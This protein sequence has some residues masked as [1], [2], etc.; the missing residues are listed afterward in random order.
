MTARATAPA[1]S[2]TSARRTTLPLPSAPTTTGAQ[3]ARRSVS[4]R[5]PAASRARCTTRSP[6]RRPGE[7]GVELA[8][9]DDAAEVRAADRDG[10]ARDG[11]ARGIDPRVGN[12]KRDAQL[13]EQAQCLGDDAPGAR[14]VPGVTGLVEEEHARGEL[15]RQ[16]SEPERRGGSGGS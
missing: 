15:R 1:P 12:R 13:L 6:A 10:A 8:P 3:Y 7:R 2:P 14:F 9:P 16:G 4:T 5:T 11:D